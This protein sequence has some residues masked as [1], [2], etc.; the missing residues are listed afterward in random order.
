AREVMPKCRQPLQFTLRGA[1]PLALRVGLGRC[2]LQALVHIGQP[3]VLRGLA[4]G[5]VL[6][7]L[8]LL[9]LA[10]DVGGESGELLMT[11]PPQAAQLEEYQRA[12]ARARISEQIAE[13]VQLLLNAD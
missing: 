8:A 6:R 11:E 3:R 2:G 9:L 5:R 12:E 10:R 1:Q 13:P 4:I 7:G